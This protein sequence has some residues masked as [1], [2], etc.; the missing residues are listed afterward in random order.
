MAWLKASLN[1]QYLVENMRPWL[2]WYF[3][4]MANALAVDLVL[5][6]AVQEDEEFKT[7]SK[8]SVVLKTGNAQDTALINETAMN[9]VDI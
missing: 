1:D 2:P 3:L 8:L 4:P 9:F 5:D 7:H 6:F